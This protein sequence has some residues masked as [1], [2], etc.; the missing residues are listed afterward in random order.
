MMRLLLF[1]QYR[2]HLSIK[3]G[4]LSRSLDKPDHDILTA[5]C[6]DSSIL[7]FGGSHHG[8]TIDAAFTSS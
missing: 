3:P 7:I 8:G 2:C 1:R 6:A 4:G 5:S